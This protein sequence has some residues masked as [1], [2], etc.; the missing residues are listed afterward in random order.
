VNPLAKKNRLVLSD[1]AVA[2]I[3]EQ[4]EWYSTQSGIP[5]WALGE[6]SHLCHTASG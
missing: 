6:S 1:A 4:A 3:V 5:L 2:D